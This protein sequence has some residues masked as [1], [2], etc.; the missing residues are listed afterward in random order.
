MLYCEN[1]HNAIFRVQ[2]VNEDGALVADS[3]NITAALTEQI[4]E[5]MQ[6][7]ECPVCTGKMPLINAVK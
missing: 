5:D 7:G 4:I 3:R 1:G 2:V 6:M